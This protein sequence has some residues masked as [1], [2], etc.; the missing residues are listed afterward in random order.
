MR[1]N[2]NG[3]FLISNSMETVPCT[4][5]SIF[6]VPMHKFKNLTQMSNYV[7]IPATL[8]NDIID[9]WQLKG[10]WGTR[11]LIDWL[12]IA[13]FKQEHSGRSSTPKIPGKILRSG[14]NH[15]LPSP[16]PVFG[17]K[18]Q[19]ISVHHFLSNRSNIQTNKQTK[20]ITLPPW[21]RWNSIL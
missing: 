10:C 3:P 1:M 6:T 16:K 9:T 13:K 21:Q 14:F 7:N 19:C 2:V 15:L 17:H 4:A 20:P 5:K 8:T 18:F 11:L 12:F